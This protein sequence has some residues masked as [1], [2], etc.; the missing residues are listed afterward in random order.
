M[1]LAIETSAA[2]CSVAIRKSNKLLLE[3]NYNAPM[4]H[5][6]LLGKLVPQALD[7]V[8]KTFDIEAHLQ[9]VG[10]ALGPGSFTGLRI[11]LSYAQGFCYGK[12]L[13]IVGIT[14]H[15]VLASQIDPQFEG[16][17]YSLIDARRGEYYLA[18]HEKT[19]SLLMPVKQY[20]IVDE[21]NLSNLITDSS[22]IVF[23]PGVRF[24]DD[25][26]SKLLEKNS[27]AFQG[28]YSA[29]IVAHL[30][31]LKFEKEGADRLEKIEPLYIRKFAGEM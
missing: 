14:N 31:Q 18:E 9:I 13:N 23:A 12:D 10:I 11:G 20:Q 22:I 28:K 6:A 8:K 3:Y 17:I 16:D 2:I 21:N 15:H 26:K 27:F 5:A 1:I 30:S 4:Q 25:F 7:E 24:S 29:A 19:G